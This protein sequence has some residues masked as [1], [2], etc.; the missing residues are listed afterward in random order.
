MSQSGY[1]A[2]TTANAV[3]PQSA[4]DMI[5]NIYMFG[6]IIIW[7]SLLL[8]L[9]MYKLDKEYPV[10]MDELSKREAREEM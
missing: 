8:V 9:S 4:I 6:M 5:V 2:S 10:I 3:Q 7:V 1:V